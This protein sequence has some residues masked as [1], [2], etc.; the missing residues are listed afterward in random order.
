MLTRIRMLHF[1]YFQLQLSLTVNHCVKYIYFHFDGVPKLCARNFIR[2]L[3]QPWAC[4]FFSSSLA[5]SPYNIIITK[6]AFSSH[7]VR[8]RVSVFFFVFYSRT[9]CPHGT[10]I[11]LPRTRGL[12]CSTPTAYS[13]LSYVYT[14][15]LFMYSMDPNRCRSMTTMCHIFKR[16]RQ[17]HFWLLLLLSIIFHNHWNGLENESIRLWHQISDAAHETRDESKHMKIN[18]SK[19]SSAWT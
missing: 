4:F 2:V 16:R 1:D 8:V 10:A 18:E 6:N 15:L 7:S 5:A 13:S 11:E 12:S 3:P 14:M 19:W 9:A 17:I